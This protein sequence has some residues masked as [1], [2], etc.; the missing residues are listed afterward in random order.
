MPGYVIHLAIANEYLK[1]HENKEDK[2]EFIKGVI[3][4]DSVKDKSITHY[5]KNSA[6]SNLYEFLCKN[7]IDNSFYR[8]YFMHL[9]TDYF[10]YNRLI[11]YPTKAIYNDYDLLNE[12]ILKKYKFDV[13][14]KIKEVIKKPKSTKLKYLSEEMITGF[15]DE[16]AKVDLYEARKDI[17]ENKEKWTTFRD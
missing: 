14:P 15:I 7:K 12:F 11:D 17:L 6:H 1:R 16:T 8:G 10:F 4:P 3:Y 5:G 9:I 2:E 13:P